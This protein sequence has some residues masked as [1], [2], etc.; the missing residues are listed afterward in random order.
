VEV[1]GK[2]YVLKRRKILGFLP[3][4]IFLIK[5]KKIVY[6]SVPLILLSF[7]LTGCIPILI[8]AGVGA[9]A[10]A[11]CKASNANH[12]QR[13]LE[14]KEAYGKYRMEMQQNNAEPL[15]F[16]DWLKEQL[17]DPK[18]AKEWKN[19]LKDLEKNKQKSE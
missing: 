13:E 4:E 6:L 3:F 7:L 2:I 15:S 10:T 18:K 1:Y 17:K 5:M 12:K 16:E 8:G 14:A 11:A 19:L 9:G